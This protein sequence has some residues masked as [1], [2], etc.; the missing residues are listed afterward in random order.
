MERGS[1]V[2]SSN[3]VSGADRFHV[4]LLFY[5]SIYQ[6]LLSISSCVFLIV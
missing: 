4:C 3:K 5:L 1:D 2:E 6:I